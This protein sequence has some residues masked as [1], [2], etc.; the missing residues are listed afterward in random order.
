MQDS[1][2]QLKKEA[3]AQVISYEFCEI[4][5]NTYFA[6]HSLLRVCKSRNSGWHV[7]FKICHEGSLYHIET[8]S[9]ICSANQ[10]TGFYMMET[11]AMKVLKKLFWKVSLKF[12]RNDLGPQ[13]L[14]LI[15]KETLTQVS[16]CEFC[17]MF[18]NS[19]LAKHLRVTTSAIGIWD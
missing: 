2:L 4:F 17:E 12:P 1:D 5:K 9:L 18:Q 10:W 15:K 6:N 13:R 16:S 7:F 19:S 8:S 3:L 14:N 11:F